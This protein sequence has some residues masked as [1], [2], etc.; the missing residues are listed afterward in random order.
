MKSQN[1]PPE[2]RVEGVGNY[3]SGRHVSVMVWPVEL[4]CFPYSTS[5]DWACPIDVLKT[6]FYFTTLYSK[7]SGLA[8]WIENCKW[9]S[10]HWIRLYLYFVYQPSE[11]CRHNPLCCFSTSVNYCCC[12][13]FRYWLSPETF[14]CNLVVYEMR[15]DLSVSLC[16][17]RSCRRNRRLSELQIEWIT[18]K[19]WYKYNCN[20]Q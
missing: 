1:T 4:C 16:C 8:S 14:G 3:I 2:L 15:L 12:C 10:C 11:F 13:L 7:V 19:Q 17:R 9:Y 18:R 6:S 20:K 5:L